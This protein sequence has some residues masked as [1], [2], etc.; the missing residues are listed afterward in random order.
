MRKL[1]KK[2]LCLILTVLM[3]FSVMAF[4][5]SA[6]YYDNEYPIVMVGGMRDDLV[7]A[8][9][10]TIYPSDVSLVE[11]FK[12]TFAKCTMEM[13]KAYGSG[14]WSKYA[15]EFH[16]MIVPVFAAIQ[17]DGDGV[18][19][20]GSHAKW[21]WTRETLLR[22]TSNYTMSDYAFEYDWRV[23]SYDVA[24]I[25]ARYIDDVLY[26]TGKDKVNLVGRCLGSNIVMCY[27]EKYGTDKVNTFV[28]YV[29]GAEGNAMIGSLLTGNLALDSDHVSAFATSFSNNFGITGDPTLDGMLTAFVS[30]INQAEL[31]GIGTGFV[32]EV[33]ENIKY[34][35]MPRTL[36]DTFASFGTLWDC[37]APEY[38]EQAKDFVFNTPELKAEYAPMLAKADRYN[39]NIK[40]HVREL[41]KEYAKE[42]N[43]EVVAKYNCDIYPIYEGC[44]VQGDGLIELERISYGAMTV[45]MG[46]TLDEKYI[47][48]RKELGLDQYISADKIVDASTCLFRDHT[49]F[50]RDLEHMNWAESVD[51]YIVDIIRSDGKMTV[52]SDKNHPQYMQFDHNTGALS[53]VTDVISDSE[54]RWNGD[55]Q[56]SILTLI[57]RILKL[58]PRFFNLIFGKLG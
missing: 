31:L 58:L 23:S 32:E 3:A 9:G 51:N 12:S 29:G 22:K 49:W 4:S 19:K 25:L 57:F 1:A 33:Y 6:L 44:E 48:Q 17:I 14:D 20:D 5:A 42:I 11:Q 2:T 52:F 8:Q 40:T 34:D 21:T 35:F 16:D 27:F 24:D 13:I 10:N 38:Y 56:S 7:D 28:S 39:T 15:D 36:R 26:V 55:L 47:S 43:I 53:P 45:N 41:L 54:D 46:E 18:V 37:C 50:I 30:L